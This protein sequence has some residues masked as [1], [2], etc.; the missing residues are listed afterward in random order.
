MAFTKSLSL[1]LAIFLTGLSAGLFYAWAVSV[2]P[3]T[4]KLL[5]LTY[6]QTMQSINKEILNPAFF[7]SFYGS[8]LL[9]MISSVQQYGQGNTFWLV[10][11]ATITYLLGTFAVTAFGNVPLNDE[12]GVL[13]LSEL[14]ETQLSDFRQYYEVRWNRLHF[15]RTL[16]AIG[17]FLLALAGSFTIKY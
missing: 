12:L 6:L 2:I 3:G 16:S 13:N 9:L 14:S 11:A 17:A 15:I 1:Y 5:D 10:I 4:K 7:L 8:L